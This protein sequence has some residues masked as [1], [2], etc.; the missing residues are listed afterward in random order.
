MTSRYSTRLRTVRAHKG[1]HP[2][3]MEELEVIYPQKE[4]MRIAGI[5][6]DRR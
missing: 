1:M 2:Y 5:P 3:S 6:T 4:A